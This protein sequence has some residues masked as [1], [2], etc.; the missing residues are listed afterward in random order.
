MADAAQ[1]R[2]LVFGGTGMLGRAVAAEGRRRGLAVLALGR[3]QAD[4]RDRDALVGWARDFRPTCVVN[5]AAFTQV[6]T[7]ETE[8]ETAHAINADAVAHV[9]AAAD[10]V[11]ARLLHVSTDYVFDGRGPDGR[12]G[13]RHDR[14]AGY[15]EDAATAP[16][17]AYGRSKLGGEAHARAYPRGLTVRTS[18][19]FGP[20]GPNFVATMRRLMREGRVPLRVVDDQV[21]RPTYTPYLARALWDLASRPEIVDVIH[22]GNRPVASWC[23]FTREIAAIVRPATEVVP[24]ATSAFP[25][26][27]PRPAYSALA[28]DRIEHA[29]GRR[30][31]TWQAGLLDYLTSTD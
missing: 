2:L 17:S 14:A 5:C 23:E 6:D 31:E 8:T 11:E 26:P 22:Y 30:V 16:A 28:V 19:L 21:G 27:A 9:V 15:V 13:H 18:W 3:G 24:V 12:S 1:Q 4:V 20:N 10:A 29:L 7:C 25:R